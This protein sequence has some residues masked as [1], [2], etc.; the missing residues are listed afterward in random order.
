MTDSKTPVADGHKHISHSHIPDFLESPLKDW[1]QI[2]CALI[3][4]AQTDDSR[5][6]PAGKVADIRKISIECNQCASGF[7]GMAE[8]ISIRN[9][10]QA[11]FPDALD[12]IA[13]GSKQLH[14]GRLNILV[15]QQ[16]H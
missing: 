8:N 5:M 13:D 3:A 15:C 6:M 10:T 16:S 7:P 2:R 9:R 14:R 12:I 1:M 11:F 4:H